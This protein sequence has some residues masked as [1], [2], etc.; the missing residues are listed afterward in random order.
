MVT[1]GSGPANQSWDM[2]L[3]ANQSRAHTLAPSVLSYQLNYARAI[4]RTNKL[5]TAR[6]FEWDIIYSNRIY[7]HSF[8]ISEGNRT[9]KIHNLQVDS[10]HHL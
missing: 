4:I 5:I 2:A 8:Q 1:D 9:Y 6:L 10:F 7:R 3:Q